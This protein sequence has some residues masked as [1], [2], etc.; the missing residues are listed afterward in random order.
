M[1][2]ADYV[3]RALDLLG[4]PPLFDPNDFLHS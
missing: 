4:V 3:L 2:S 1:Y